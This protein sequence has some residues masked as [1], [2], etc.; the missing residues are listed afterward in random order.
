MAV[1]EKIV[2]NF[3]QG[4]DYLQK[5][6]VLAQQAETAKDTAVV[7]ANSARSSATTATN[8]AKIA[9]DSANEA[10]QS[11]E[12]AKAQADMAEI[13]SQQAETYAQTAF[14]ASAP[15]WDSSE[16]YNYPQCVA[17]TDGMTYRCVGTN[18]TG[19]DIPG[20]SDK[21]VSITLNTDNFFDVDIEGRFM[22]SLYPTF[23]A[24]WV[25]DGNG[26]IEPV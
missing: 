7:G 8:A 13:S 22:P 3:T 12:I 5:V 1:N 4:V 25:L 24:K 16:T 14:G 19:S 11:A 20:S 2:V 26:N 6:G 9:S 17:Y 23:S 15:A 10:K 18:V 21:W